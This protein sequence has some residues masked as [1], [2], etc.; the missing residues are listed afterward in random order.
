MV[1]NQGFLHS[2]GPPNWFPGRGRM[3]LRL[4]WGAVKM[5]FFKS[6]KFYDV[7]VVCKN[8]QTYCKERDT[9]AISSVENTDVSYYK[10]EA[11]CL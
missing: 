6:I 8:E 10:Q 1:L 4:I 11:I 5:S 9:A 2:P 7:L 3:L